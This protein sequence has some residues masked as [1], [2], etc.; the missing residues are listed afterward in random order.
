MLSTEKAEKREGDGG[1]PGVDKEDYRETDRSLL[2]LDVE[3]GWAGVGWWW[4]G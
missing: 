3:L 1:R 2:R 4:A